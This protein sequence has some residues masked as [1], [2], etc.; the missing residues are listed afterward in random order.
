M[1]DSTTDNT[2]I[3]LAVTGVALQVKNLAGAGVPSNVIENLHLRCRVQ[4]VLAPATVSTSLS[5][6]AEGC[7][8]LVGA[9]PVVPAPPLGHLRC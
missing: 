4:K 7:P 9:V 6:A 5:P 3:K 2:M 1:T 8:V